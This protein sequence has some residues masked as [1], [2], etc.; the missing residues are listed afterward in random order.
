MQP[1]PNW[2][3]N[4][5]ASLAYSRQPTAS[6]VADIAQIFNILKKLLSAKKNISIGL[7]GKEEKSFLSAV[8]GKKGSPAPNWGG[9]AA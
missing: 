6:A 2:S 1:N 7:E 5:Y 4:Y 3:E 8:V 9:G